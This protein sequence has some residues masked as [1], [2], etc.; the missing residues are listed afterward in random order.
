MGNSH[1]EKTGRSFTDLIR[2]GMFGD[3]II[4]FNAPIEEDAAPWQTLNESDSSADIMV[5]VVVVLLIVASHHHHHHHHLI[6]MM[7]MITWTYN[8]GGGRTKKNCG[9][10]ASWPKKEE[11]KRK[12]EG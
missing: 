6:I 4:G 8:V 7:M 2:P 3:H 5:V 9:K 10:W 1:I 11:G 12:K